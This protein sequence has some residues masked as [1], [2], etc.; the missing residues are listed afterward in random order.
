MLIFISAAGIRFIRITRG[1][2]RSAG[3]NAFRYAAVAWRVVSLCSCDTPFIPSCT[4]ERLVQRRGG[5]P[6][7]WV[8]DG[9][10]DHPAIALINRSLISALEDYPPQ[11]SDALWY[12]C[13]SP[14]GIPLISAT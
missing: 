13:V 4:V 8:H 5:A 10:R 2:P 6:V 1:L 11:E 9:E 7:V 14:E 3:G 12:L